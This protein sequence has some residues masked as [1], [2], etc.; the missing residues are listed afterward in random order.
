MTGSADRLA[1]LTT[2]MRVAIV[3]LVALLGSQAALWNELRKFGA[4][5]SQISTRL[6]RIETKID[7]R[8]FN[9]RHPG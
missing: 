8:E 2:L 6:E 4:G 3:M 5:F 9:N 1:R 7:L